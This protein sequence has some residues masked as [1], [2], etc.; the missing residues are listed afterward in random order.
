MKQQLESSAC[1]TA[2][3]SFV[4]RTRTMPSR[5]D[6]ETIQRNVAVSA[7][8][9]L[10]VALP[11]ARSIADGL[12][13][14]I[15]FLFLVHSWRR[16]DFA[17]LR[18]PWTMLALALWAWIVLCAIILGQLPGIEQSLATLR[19][20]LFVAALENWVL[21][22]PAV[23]RWLWY[24]V[25]GMACW[26]FI[27][28][29][30]QLLFGA[31]LFGVPRFHD[32]ALT[33]PFPKPIA[34]GTY[35]MLFFPAFLPLCFRL[36]HRHA[37]LPRLLGLALPMIAGTMM[38]LIGQRMPTLLCAFG[39]I[40]TGLLFHRVRWAVCLT[41]ALSAVLLA[42]TPIISPPTFTKLVVH[43]TEQM[44]HFWQSPYGLTFD[45]AVEMI[46]V[47][48]WVGLGW[49]GFRANCAQPIYLANIQNMPASL[50]ALEGGCSIH[51]HNYWL[52]IATTCGLPGLV[53]FGLLVGRWLWRLRGG[54]A[55]QLNARRAALMIILIVAFWPIASTTSMFTLPNAGWLF[56]MAG[57]GLAE[58]RYANRD[59]DDAQVA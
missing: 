29:V 21:A 40:L 6:H 16:A 32:G 18:A 42:L 20:F 12:L 2:W 44:E 51:P 30:Q 46:K 36:L 34:G 33:G 4:D 8:L 56:L 25:L 41:L 58:A 1:M 3:T 14:L 47:N 54:G 23:R 45:R 59:S 38:I 48:P 9:L 7:L 15:A 22:V 35:L 53:L 31:N 52:Q 26:I 11:Y 17:W 10:P 50:N 39:L 55:Y 43:F 24:V 37:T 13:T 5:Y 27:E 19:L 28:G 49:D 57:W